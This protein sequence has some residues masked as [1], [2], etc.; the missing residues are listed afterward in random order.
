MDNRK[1]RTVVLVIF[2]I[3]ILGLSCYICVVGFQNVN[4][5]RE[6][7]QVRQGNKTYDT[8][9]TNSNISTTVPEKAKIIFKIKYNKSGELKTE[10][11]EL[12][13]KLAGKSKN[14][15]ENIYKTAG[16][17]VNK[18]GA[19]EV[20]LVKEV[21]KYEP[22]KYV[23]GIKN[24]LIAIYKTDNQGNMFIENEKRDVTDIKTSKLKEEDIRLLTKG[25]KYFECNTRDEAESRL[26]DY[27]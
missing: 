27:E 19:K 4:M 12:A 26:E 23:L 13:G 6:I 3:L 2:T 8:V 16:Y 21:D 10:K 24:G 1:V 15:V 5:N 20:V 7:K 11:E 18:F 22:N 9:N 25:D 17:K 14:E